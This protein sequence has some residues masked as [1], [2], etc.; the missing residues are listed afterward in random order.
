[1]RMFSGITPVCIRDSG[2]KWYPGLELGKLGRPVLDFVSDVLD[3]NGCSRDKAELP[4]QLDGGQT[5]RLKGWYRK[6]S[7]DTEE[8][9][10][11]VMI[12]GCLA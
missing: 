2:T 9:G 11:R 8:K 3:G 4:L 12:W 6:L 5:V 1:M 7:G 10:D